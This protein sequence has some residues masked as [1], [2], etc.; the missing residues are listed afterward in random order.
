[1]CS[2]A[3]APVRQPFFH[4]QPKEPRSAAGQSTRPGLNSTLL[5]SSP[6]HSTL[7]VLPQHAPFNQR[8]YPYSND[9]YQPPMTSPPSSY[10]RSSASRS[11]AQQGYAPYHPPY[12]SSQED[13]LLLAGTPSSTGSISSVAT[14]RSQEQLQG[15]NMRPEYDPSP[16][17]SQSYN[18]MDL[19]PRS[20]KWATE[21][22]G[23]SHDYSQPG[24]YDSQSAAMGLAASMLPHSQ[25]SPSERQAFPI[26]TPMASLP[27]FDA[28]ATESFLGGFNTL[29]GAPSSTSFGF[30]H[31][32]SP[33]PS[34]RQEF[35][36]QIAVEHPPTFQIPPSANS[37]QR[38]SPKLEYP[39]SS[40][41]PPRGFLDMA[42]VSPSPTI[43]PKLL[44]TPLLPSPD[45]T[46]PLATIGPTS[47]DVGS[48]GSSVDGDF[49]FDHES[50]SL[51]AS[52]KSRARRNGHVA[53]NGPA[54][55]RQRKASF[56]S[57]SG[58][59]DKRRS[60]GSE[61]G[62]SEYEK[63]D[64]DDDE[65]EE[66]FARR[67]RRRSSR[68]SVNGVDDLSSLTSP[69]RIPIPVP[70]PNLTKKSRGRRVPTEPTIVARDGMVKNSRTYMCTVPECGKCFARGEHL[71]RHVRSIHT[72]EKPHKCPYPGCG[73][74]FSRHDNLGQHMRVH[75]GYKPKVN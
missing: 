71:K 41:S 51:E 39:S 73:K 12:G 62:E 25:T 48:P 50:A 4:F 17:P 52:P 63:D 74:D 19:Y 28:S 8:N 33:Q 54:R 53:A 44:M 46:D 66:Y 40:T 64:D 11:S 69:R 1:M 72:N 15:Y 49:E 45:S 5:P 37:D 75:K 16:A 65:E 20:Q 22:H 57:S 27:N 42:G 23:L 60:G 58:D 59:S 30:H 34:E 38:Q 32:F 10:L 35:I 24:A 9:I 21:L 55:K 18:G 61:S 14:D 29:P 2:A 6:M 26:S 13:D 68:K 3:I 31:P 56:T 43:S 7:F 67:T 70:V 36:H 47:N